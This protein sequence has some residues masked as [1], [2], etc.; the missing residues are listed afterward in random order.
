MASPDSAL[1]SSDYQAPVSTLAELPGPPR[2]PILG[3]MTSFRDRPP[4]LVME[5]WAAQYGQMYQFSLGRQR[6][7]VISDA[8]LV[9]KILRARPEDFRRQRK[10]ADAIEQTGFRGVFTAEGKDWQRQRRLVMQGLTP[11]VVSAASSNIRTVTDRLAE[12]WGQAADESQIVDVV[13]DL[14]RYSMDVVLWLS[15]GIDLNATENPDQDL[16][17]A[18][19]TWFNAI[20]RRVRQPVPYWRYFKLPVDRRS[21]RAIELLQKTARDAIEAVRQNRAQWQGKPSN[22]LEALLDESEKPDS[23]FTADNVFGNAVTMLTA[24]E[25]TTA[26]AMSWLLYYCSIQPALATQLRQSIL[27]VFGSKPIELTAETIRQLP[28]LQAV[29]LEVMRRRPVAPMIGLTTA[30]PMTIAGLEVPAQ[31]ALTLLPRVANRATP[32][33]LN[34]DELELPDLDSESRMSANAS[35]NQFAFGGGPRLCPGRYLALTE[36]THLAAM[37]LT[38]FEFSLAVPK[39]DIEEAFT[40]TMGPKTLPLTFRRR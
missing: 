12:R 34:N 2:N 11:N 31:Q 20:G 16:Q 30:R 7:L 1:I 4:H 29:C 17:T 6:N 3:N 8:E 28:Q 35:S 38:R 14:K 37:A 5:Q 32:A 13:G 19:D 25:D 18:V 15:L 33:Q 22:I 23:D 27:T 10:L 24:G 40:F 26:N 39:Q 21:D 9:R 36:M